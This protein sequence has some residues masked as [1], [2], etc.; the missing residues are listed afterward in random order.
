MLTSTLAEL[1]AENNT[2]AKQKPLNHL[3]FFMDSSQKS[4]D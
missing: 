1:S 4:I 2:A 3:L